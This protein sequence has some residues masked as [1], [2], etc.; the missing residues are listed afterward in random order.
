[1]FIRRLV[2]TLFL[3][4]VLAGL[5]V[6]VAGAGGFKTPALIPAAPPATNVDLPAICVVH[7]NFV[8]QTTE[9][10]CDAVVPN[11]DPPKGRTSVKFS[12]FEG[13]KG[14]CKVTAWPD[15][16]VAMACVFKGVLL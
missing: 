15:G 4:A 16:S 7:L 5:T 12:N 13:V 6:G 14:S 1:M 10:N 11:P 2:L 3:G 9:V 8:K